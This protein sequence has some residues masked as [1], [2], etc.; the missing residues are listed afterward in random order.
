MKNRLIWI[1]FKLINPFL[2]F[3]RFIFRPKT[4][5]AKCIIQNNGEI[6]LIRNTYGRRRWTFPGGGIKKGEVPEKA[7]KRE[8]FEEVGIKADSLRLIGNFIMSGKASEYRRDK[9]FVF[10]TKVRDKEFKIDKLEIL[11]AKWFPLSQLPK[12]AS[13]AR[14][15]LKLWQSKNL[16]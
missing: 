16:I 6:L 9:V 10:W 5:G 12:I 8:I 2:N 7:I 3:Y 11:E 15:I 4:Y 13:Y 14:E 1:I